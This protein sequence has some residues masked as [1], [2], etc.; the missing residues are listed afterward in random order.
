MPLNIPPHPETP[1]FDEL[2]E[3]SENATG[4]CLE[5]GNSQGCVEPDAQN[6][7]CED[8]GQPYVFG[9]DVLILNEIFR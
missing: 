6:Y 3:G 5:C 2:V 4:F 1:S 8:C 7:P 9:T